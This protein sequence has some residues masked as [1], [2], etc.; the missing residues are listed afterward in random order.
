MLCFYWSLKSFGYG[1]KDILFS[2]LFVYPIRGLTHHLLFLVNLQQDGT[3]YSTNYHLYELVCKV[4]H[5]LL[6]NIF[7]LCDIF[8]SILIHLQLRSTKTRVSLFQ[9]IHAHSNSKNT[10]IFFCHWR[11]T[12]RT[13][14]LVHHTAS[15]CIN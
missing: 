11:P 8:W 5:K 9:R 14:L 10:K 1:H 13:D 12:I 2:N 6:H 7:R 15:V 4:F 3:I